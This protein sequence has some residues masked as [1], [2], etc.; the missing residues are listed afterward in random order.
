MDASA[1]ELYIGGHFGQIIGK[2]E[3]YDRPRI[4]SLEVGTGAATDFRVV[5]D[6]FFGVWTITATPQFLAVGGAFENVNG[7][8]QRGFARFSG[9]T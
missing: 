3:H 9:T 5:L 7:Q 6:S 1:T 2:P 4:A 8:P